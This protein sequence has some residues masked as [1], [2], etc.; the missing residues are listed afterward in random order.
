[1]INLGGDDLQATLRE[2]DQAIYNHGQWIKDL[3]R[4]IICG[5]PYDIRD[6]A[7]DAHQQCRFGQWFYGNPPQALREHPAFSAIESQHRD[8]HRLAAHLLISAAS[9]TLNSPR[10]YDSFTNTVDRLNLEMYSLKRELEE[11]FN[12]R[13]VLTGAENRMSMLT[14]LRELREL[15]NRRIQ[16]CAIVI[17]DLDHFKAVNDT[18]GHPVGDQILVSWVRYLKHHLRP[19]DTIYRY[20]GE[21]FLM[22][23]PSTG[24]AAAQDLIERVREGLEATAI[25]TDKME[26]V[27]VTASF[28]IALLD[29]AV[30]VEESIGRA[31]AA[32]YAAKQAG[33]NRARV[34]DSTMSTSP[35]AQK[36]LE[37][38]AGA[39]TD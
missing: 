6:I 32:L 20:G 11:S 16:E 33:R 9:G 27:S 37:D 23:F 7:E 21:E 1:M 35:D 31:D 25:T 39:E 2:L 26:S 22:T 36:G 24:L 5:L 29:A 34:W 30:P 3:T 28:G 17:M 8:M 19:Y 13:D 38:E 15:V 10:E 14:R 12:S 18:Y 4:S